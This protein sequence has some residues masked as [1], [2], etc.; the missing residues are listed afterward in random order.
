VIPPGVELRE[1]TIVLRQL[2]GGATVFVDGPT[3][4]PHRYDGGELCMWWPFDVPERRWRRQDGAARYSVMSL[5]ISC[6]K[7]GG[8]TPFERV[9]DEAL[10]AAQDGQENE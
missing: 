5:R 3:G 9:G 4:S 8:V 10:H 2:A 7:S 6:G 1:V